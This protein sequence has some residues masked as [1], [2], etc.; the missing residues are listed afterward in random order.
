[1]SYIVDKR[2][3]YINSQ[4]RVANSDSTNSDFEVKLNVPEKFDSCVVLDISIPKSYDLIQA[5]ANTF[6]LN[7]GSSS[8]IITVPIGNYSSTSFSKVVVSLLNTNS[9]N[10]YT[11][12]M[13]LNNQ[14]KFEYKVSNNN[15][16]Q[17]SF[18]FAAYLNEQCGFEQKSTNTFVNNALVSANCVDFQRESTLFLRSDMVTIGNGDNVLQQV[19]CEDTADFSNIVWRCPDVIAYAKPYIVNSTNQFHF[20]LTDENGI[21]IDTKNRNMVFTLMIFKKSPVYEN[22]NSFIKYLN[23]FIESYKNKNF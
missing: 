20:W 17:P 10:H 1:M 23:N 11:Y 16:V 2:I 21:R 22:M 7:E 19:F 15:N 14:G 5:N 13:T 4:N 18:T 8:A 6:T 12:A 9:P 3:Y